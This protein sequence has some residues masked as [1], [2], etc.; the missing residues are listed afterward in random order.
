MRGD[1]NGLKR[2]ENR[3]DRMCGAQTCLQRCVNAGP[4]TRFGITASG[5]S[6]QSFYVGMESQINWASLPTRFNSGRTN[7]QGRKRAADA[8]EDCRNTHD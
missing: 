4:P 1:R 7:G 5:S 3:P 8:R 2:K 6:L